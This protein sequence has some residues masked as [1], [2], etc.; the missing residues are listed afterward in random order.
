MNSTFFS[1]N[2]RR[3]VESDESGLFVFTAFVAMQ[4]RADAAFKFEQDANFWYLSGVDEA[5]CWLIID[6]HTGKSWLA[7]P[8]IDKIRTI[9]D[10]EADIQRLKDRSGVDEVITGVE[11]RALLQDFAKNRHTVSSA[12]PPAWHKRLGFHLNPAHAQLQRWLK[13]TFKEVKDCSQ[14]VAALR[15]I[16]QPVEVDAL[17]KAIDLTNTSIA[18]ALSKL[19]SMQFEYEFEAELN[20]SFRIKGGEGHAYDPIVAAGK[21][22]CT[23][24]YTSNS[25]TL[26]PVLDRWLL[27]DVGARYDHYCADIT[28]T[29]PLGEYSQRQRDVY[30]AVKNVHDIALQHCKPGIEL[31]KYA[32]VVSESMA[33][34]L[35]SLKLIS[36]TKDQKGLH[37]YFPHAIS[38]SLGIDVHDT[39]GGFSSFKPGMVL[40]VEPGI[41]IPEENT[42]IRLEND[43]L[44]TEDGPKVMSDE[45]PSDL[46]RLLSLV[47]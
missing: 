11:A 26:R 24:H 43:I 32:Q 17:Q 39:F 13:R 21:N 42:G 29:L 7:V 40:T 1:G 27:F 23:L 30:E 33:K 44:I 10:G 12:L 14:Q 19:N 25:D 5:D 46:N 31:K 9:F 22:A 38:H 35:V 18:G 34:E 28:R 8:K 2:R 4:R 41:Y 37:H 20:R 45:L 36:S 3:L 16:K 6:G 15:A 47:G